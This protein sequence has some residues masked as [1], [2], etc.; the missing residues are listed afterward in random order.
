MVYLI[1]TNVILILIF[2]WVIPSSLEPST[3]HLHLS[4]I[5][6]TMQ[7]CHEYST[8]YTTSLH[9]TNTKNKMWSTIKCSIHHR[10][11]MQQIQTCCYISYYLIN[12]SNTKRRR[13]EMR[14]SM[15]DD[16][17]KVWEIQIFSPSPHLSRIVYSL[18]RWDLLHFILFSEVQ[19]V[20]DWVLIRWSCL[21]C[22]WWKALWKKLRKNWCS[23]FKFAFRSLF[24]FCVAVCWLYIELQCYVSLIYMIVIV[25]YKIAL[26]KCLDVL[27]H[28]WIM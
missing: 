10:I 22:E 15:L 17:Q 2:L 18:D 27:E 5:H 23:I 24:V 11:T 20:G 12:N 19:V 4:V 7:S 9:Q 1:P 8:S 21:L 13:K 25:L 3:Y 14:F 16:K 6:H 26:M 28:V